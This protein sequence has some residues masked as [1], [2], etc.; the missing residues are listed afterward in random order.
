MSGPAD[1]SAI[2][3]LLR[4]GGAEGGLLP[5]WVALG[6][7]LQASQDQLVAVLAKAEASP[8]GVIRGRRHTMLDN[9]DV[10]STRHARGFV[11]RMPAELTGMTDLFVSNGA[12]HQGP[13]DGGLVAIIYSKETNT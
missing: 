8:D 5:H 2:T 4:S 13:P 9:S 10:S 12:Q 1:V 7:D 11:G 3:A 6:A